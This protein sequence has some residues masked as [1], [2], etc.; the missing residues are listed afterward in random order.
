MLQ[1][2]YTKS[3]KSNPLMTASCAKNDTEEE[4]AR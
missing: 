2:T 3:K 4:N 1:A